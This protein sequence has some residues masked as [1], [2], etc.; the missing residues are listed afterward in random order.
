M[1]ILQIRNVNK[2]FV[3]LKALDEVNLDV[4]PGTV[5]A[6]IGP[7]GAGKSTTMKMVTGFVA[8]S[9][10]TARVCGHDIQTETLAAQQRTG[11]L[12]EGA[13]LYAEMTPAQ[14]LNFIADV[15]NID[16]ARRQERLS[17]VLS[18]IHI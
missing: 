5:H 11:Y 15:R 16:G 17:E 14:F 7:N 1:S 13:P 12:P 4:E 8:P 10:G 2:R 3:G 6:I 9:D 18:L